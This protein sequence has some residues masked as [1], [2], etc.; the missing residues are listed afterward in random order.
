MRAWE[1]KVVNHTISNRWSAKSQAEEIGGF[2]TALEREGRNGWELVEYSSVP[3]TNWSD[4][5]K[6]YAYLMIFKR[7]GAEIS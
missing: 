1:Y 6:A 5:V 4:K 3:I 2:T 7:P